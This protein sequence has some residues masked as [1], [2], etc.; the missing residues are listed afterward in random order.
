MPFW[1]VSTSD[2]S[3]ICI[4]GDH[5]STFL[6]YH[7]EENRLILRPLFLASSETIP[8]LQFQFLGRNKTYIDVAKAYRRYLQ[9]RNELPSL[10]EKLDGKPKLIHLLEG[11]IIKFPIYM[12]REQRPD[13]NGV[14]ASPKVFNYQSFKDVAD[15]LTDMKENGIDRL[16]AVW[17][18]WGK[19]GYDRLHP[20]ILP[21]NP[22]IGGA[23]AFADAN[24]RI[25]DCG[26]AIGFHD[27]YADIYSDAPSFE[28]GIHCL[29]GRDGQN[30][31]GGF[32]AGGQCWLLCSTEGLK[33]AKRNFHAM[34]ELGPID[35]CYIDVLAA[36]NL[37]GCNSP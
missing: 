31:K 12:R 18:G 4:V 3:E 27:N 13:S 5:L 30:V 36:S 6:V 11:A 34:K 22:D 2:H 17:W 19:E 24:Y 37:V 25:A 10:V 20:D 26:F 9:D 14:T 7:P 16:L 1:G 35:A 33:F 32:W 21:P 15:V 23:M 29:V 28:S 8:R